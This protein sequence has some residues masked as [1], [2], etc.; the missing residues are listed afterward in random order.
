MIQ[1]TVIPK[2]A[3]HQETGFGLSTPSSEHKRLQVVSP[4]GTVKAGLYDE[5]EPGVF[6]TTLSSSLGLSLPNPA[7]EIDMGVKNSGPYLLF[8]LEVI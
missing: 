3:R 7:P 6:S 5:E 8:L 2:A 1:T 4:G